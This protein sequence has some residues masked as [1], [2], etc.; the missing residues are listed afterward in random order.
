MPSPEGGKGGYLALWRVPPL[1]PTIDR[2]PPSLPR[3]ADSGSDVKDRFNDICQVYSGPTRGKIPRKEA[4][5]C[6][7]PVWKSFEN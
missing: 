3:G 2:R 4:F 1:H 6:T 7:S 5:F